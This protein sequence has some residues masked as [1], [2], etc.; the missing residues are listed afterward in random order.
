MYSIHSLITC[1]CAPALGQA[2]LGTGLHREQGSP[3]PVS[4]KLGLARL[5]LL[6]SWLK[7]LPPCRSKPR[8]VL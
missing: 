1:Y 7:D 5:G 2:L 8:N 4:S 6:S 3:G